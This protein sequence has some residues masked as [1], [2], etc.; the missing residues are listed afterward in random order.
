MQIFKVQGKEGG[1]KGL[2]KILYSVITVNHTWQFLTNN[3]ADAF[4]IIKRKIKLTNKLKL[5]FK[6]S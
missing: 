5:L 1:F 4:N 3:Y 2:K 6:T